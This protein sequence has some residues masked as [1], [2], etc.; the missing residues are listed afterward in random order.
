VKVN[1][2]LK[3]QKRNKLSDEHLRRVQTAATCAAHVE[4]HLFIFSLA[5]NSLWSITVSYLPLILRIGGSC[6]RRTGDKVSD[7]D[8]LELLDEDVT[9][10]NPA[11]INSETVVSSHAG[12]SESLNFDFCCFVAVIIY[13]AN[14]HMYQTTE[15]LVLIYCINCE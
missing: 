12:S 3:N 4:R 7:A 2:F 5:A 13:I 6:C 10:S 14:G 9:S 1:L 15:V 11:S 8:R